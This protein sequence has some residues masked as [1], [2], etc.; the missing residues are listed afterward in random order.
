[1][2]TAE[3]GALQ[4]ARSIVAE[5]TGLRLDDVAPTAGIETLP[6]WDS[7]AHINAMLAIESATGTQIGPDDIA[8]LVSVPAIAAYLR[9]LRA[10]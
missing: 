9:G 10:C 3:D 4:Q 1:M 5:A 2:T 6:E 7:I 8:G